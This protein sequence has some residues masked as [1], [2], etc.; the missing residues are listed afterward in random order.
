MR[1]QEFKSLWDDIEN[2]PPPVSVTGVKIVDAYEF[3]DEVLKGDMSQASQIVKDLYSGVAY[4]LKNA[5]TEEEC[6]DII[7]DVHMWGKQSDPSYHKIEGGPFANFHHVQSN[8]QREVP[9]GYH[10]NEHSYYFFGWNDDDLG[11]YKKVEKYW[12]AIKV[13]SGHDQGKFR[14]APPS[15]GVV[16]RI[17]VLHYPAGKGYI[18]LHADPCRDQKTLLGCA[19][20]QIG[21]DYEYGDQGFS[22]YDNWDNPCHLENMCGAGD[23]ICVYPNMHHFVPVVRAK[24]EAGLDDPERAGRWYMSLFSVAAHDSKDRPIAASAGQRENDG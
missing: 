11:L 22:V 10:S 14:N 20:T 17:T 13:L 7:R 6:Q 3:I 4:I 24:G 18:G 12:G 1:H 2:G 15:D 9:G 16:D 19:L 5:L 8:L 21:R 23:F